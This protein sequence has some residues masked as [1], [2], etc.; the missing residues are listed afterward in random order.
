MITKADDRMSGSADGEDD[1]NRGLYQLYVQYL[2]DELA[3]LAATLND[4][5][6]ESVHRENY[7][8]EPYGLF[9]LRLDSM[10]P[11]E[12]VVYEQRLRDG[13]EVS[14]R[15]DESEEMREAPVDKPGTGD[16]NQEEQAGAVLNWLKTKR[17][18]PPGH[19]H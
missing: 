14:R 8:P 12:R 2:T 18:D 10:D 6:M 3:S 5:G 16:V 9:C 4:P 15:R 1:P 19:T 13:F 17:G 11:D 7:I